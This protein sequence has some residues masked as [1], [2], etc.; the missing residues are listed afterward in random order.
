MNK[1]NTITMPFAA[2]GILLLAFVSCS[3]KEKEQITGSGNME[4]TEVLISAKTAGQVLKLF[5]EE[6][7]EVQEGQ[8]IAIIDTEKVFLQKQQLLAGLDELRLNIRNAQRVASLANDNL[9]NAKKKYERIKA[10]LA[11][12]SATQQQY[13]DVETALKAAETQHEN[14]RTSLL[15]LDAK[16]A[17]LL[18]QLELIQ[19]QLRDA[20]IKSPLAGMILEKYVEPGETIRLGGPMVNIADVKKLWIK[21]YLSEAELGK[22]K[23]GGGADLKITSFAER[24]FPGK[25]SWI[26]SKAEFTP[27]NVQTKEARADLVYAI[28]V[29]IE[30]PEGILKIGMPADITLRKDF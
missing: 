15:A 16:E 10:L 25:I 3:K 21:I 11:E 1:T 2:I 27:K 6:G 24:S 14:A 4:A 29:N 26:S 13:D 5:V 8:V 19:S 30:N 20:C 9:I 18:A 22:L 28:K 17:Q 23:I 7:S 12:S